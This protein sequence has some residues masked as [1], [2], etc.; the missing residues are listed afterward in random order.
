MLDLGRAGFGED[1][2]KERQDGSRS[3]DLRSVGNV[4]H[5]TLTGGPEPGRT[6]PGYMRA[7]GRRARVVSLIQG[8]RVAL[9]TNVAM[10]STVKKY[11]G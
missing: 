6:L 1:L 5:H 10:C 2:T 4:S 11:R 7:A 8:R 3:V 9:I